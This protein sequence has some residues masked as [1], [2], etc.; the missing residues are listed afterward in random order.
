MVE[1]LQAL[2]GV[3]VPD[4]F[5]PLFVLLAALFLLFLLS[6]FAEMLKLVVLGR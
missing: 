1:K 6:Y 3:S 2:L 4:Q 5:E